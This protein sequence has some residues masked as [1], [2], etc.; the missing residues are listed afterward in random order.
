MD[1]FSHGLWPYLMT[2][3]KPWRVWAALW[4]VF[5]DVGTIPQI[6]YLM[7]VSPIGSWRGIDFETLWIPD[8]WMLSYRIT[9]SFVTLFLV[10]GLYGLFRR[11]VA[12]PLFIGW[13]THLFLD[14]FT[15]AGVYANE[16]LFPLSRFTVSGVFWSNP[17]IF[18]PNWIALGLICG[19]FIFRRLRT[20]RL[21]KPSPIR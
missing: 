16:P 13:G 21:P 17:W 14:L 10:V 9:H 11:R 3:K 5:P 4:G 6:V 18:I 1:V 20:D 15:H 19:W 12:W 7:V 8:A 2:V